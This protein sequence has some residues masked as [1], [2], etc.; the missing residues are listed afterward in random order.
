MIELENL[1]RKASI[2]VVG[3]G[4]GGGNAVNTMIAADVQGVE[5]I[6]ANTDAQV[7]ECNYAPRKLQLGEN[8][9]KGLGAGADPEIGRAAALEDQAK[10]AEVLG[11]ADMVFV[12]AGMG[13]GTGTGA[14][15][16]IAQVARDL[17]ALTVGVVTKPFHF[18]GKKRMRQALEGIA[19]LRKAVDALIVI[20]N[21]K[22]QN[23]VSET[24]SF[25][26]AFKR[27]DEVLLHAVNSISDLILVPGL[28]NVDFADVRKVLQGR[29]MALMGSGRGTGTN[30]TVEAT[31][32]AIQSPLLEDVTIEGATGVLMN[33]TGGSNVTLAEVSEAGELIE[34]AAHEE[35]DVIWGMVIDPAMKDEVRVTVIATG[36]DS[37][38]AQMRRQSGIGHHHRPAPPKVDHHAMPPPRP[39]VRHDPE[40][41]RHEIGLGPSDEDELDI[42]TFLRRKAD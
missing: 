38:E 6:A 27:V 14:A 22:L 7:L 37:Q 25:T 32:Q 18:E 4:G 24:T 12:T 26:D 11:G 39:L 29:G 3:V 35:A 16:I 2:K 40:P 17:G 15:P 42:P 10:I 34:A 8:L 23:V 36:F 19:E 1:D 30:R 21:A 28:I 41:L 5:F 9:T 33:I 31:Q 13:G 20:P